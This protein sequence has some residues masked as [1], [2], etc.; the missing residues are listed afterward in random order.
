M[1][2]VLVLPYPSQG[3]INPMI[4][5]SKLLATKGPKITLVTTLNITNSIKPQAGPISIASISDGYDEGGLSSAPNLEAYLE[6]LGIVGSKTLE[7]L[8]EEFNQSNNPFTCIVYDTYVPWA[9]DVARKLGLPCVA[10]STQSCAVSAIYNYVNKGIV[11]V[12]K[13]GAGVLGFGLPPMARS[14]FPSFSLRDGSYPTLAAFALSQFNSGGKDD[15]VLFNSFDELENEVILPLE[16]YFHARNIGP[17]VP[18][19]PTTD[20]HTNQYDINLLKPEEDTCLNWLNTKPAASVIY[21]SFGS[22]AFLNPTQMEELL[23]G[24]KSSNK[25]FLWVIRAPLQETLPQD[26]QEN[27]GEKGLIVTWSPQLKVLT[28][29]AIG[30][31]I[32]H[33]GWNSTLEAVSFGVPMVAMAQWTDQPTNAKYIEDVWKVGIRVRVDERG[34]VRREE[35]KRCVEEVMD[36]E[37]GEEIRKNAERFKEQAKEAIGKGGSSDRNLDEFVEYLNE[38]DG[39][40]KM[41]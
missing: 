8:I 12:P 32:T 28:N 22:F 35:V 30:C 4:Q 21:I 41:A 17:C 19:I 39:K 23:E 14:E 25:Y 3:H 10:F 18:L 13:V 38:M 2:H 5:F 26:F 37:R 40:K 31:F 15:W 11:E 27:L 36:G 16:D 9:V 20:G 24:L 29:K 6:S 1:A 33:C 34:I 7:K